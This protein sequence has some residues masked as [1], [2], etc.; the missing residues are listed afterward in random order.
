MIDLAG[1]GAERA[2]K[3]GLSGGSLLS[4]FI[5]NDP[6]FLMRQSFKMGGVVWVMQTAVPVRSYKGKVHLFFARL[7]VDSMIGK[8]VIVGNNRYVY[9]FD[10][11]EF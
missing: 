11:K 7:L 2:W 6:N 9:S 1:T 4:K 5:E 8:S 10:S 3:Q